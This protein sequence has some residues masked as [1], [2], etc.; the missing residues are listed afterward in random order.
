MTPLLYGSVLF[1]ALS[2]ANSCV[3][4]AKFVTGTLQLVA[5]STIPVVEKENSSCHFS[6]HS[7]VIYSCF[8]FLEFAQ[9]F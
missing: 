2:L 6:S 9:V 7:V 4:T 3:I 5:G 1:I 8:F